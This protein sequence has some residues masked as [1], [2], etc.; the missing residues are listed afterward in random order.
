MAGVIPIGSGIVDFSRV[1][2][3]VHSREK[4]EKLE[5][6]HRVSIEEASSDVM[7]FIHSMSCP[8]IN[9]LCNP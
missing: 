8:P 3:H 7:L 5:I 4:Y 6:Q 2:V 1:R 9:R